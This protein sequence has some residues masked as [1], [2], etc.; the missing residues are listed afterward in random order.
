MQAK[1]KFIFNIYNLEDKT[2]NKIIINDLDF[3]LGVRNKNIELNNIFE[4]YELNIGLEIMN[5]QKEQFNFI[6]LLKES[7][8]IND[9][10]WFLSFEKIKRNKDNLYY[11]D[12]LINVKGNLIIGCLPHIYNPNLYLK[13]NSMSIYSWILDFKNIYYFINNTNYISGKKKQEIPLLNRK[14]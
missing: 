12:D 1:E 6:N 14:A 4:I 9:Y 10:S 3:I 8:I 7:S 11:L 13:D 5:S 2:N